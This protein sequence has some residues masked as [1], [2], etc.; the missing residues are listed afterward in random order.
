[1]HPNTVYTK[2]IRMN[3][4]RGISFIACLAI[5]AGALLGTAAYA[6][7]KKMNTAMYD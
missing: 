4:T 7:D 5:A 6:D 2:D 1:M 3:L